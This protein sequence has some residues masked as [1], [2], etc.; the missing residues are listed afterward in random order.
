M[1]GPPCLAAPGLTTGC[2]DPVFALLSSF[3]LIHVVLL[4]SFC[5]LWAEAILVDIC[6]PTARSLH[7][8]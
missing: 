1:A 6:L 4:Y 5:V 7:D 8:R 2:F 3:T